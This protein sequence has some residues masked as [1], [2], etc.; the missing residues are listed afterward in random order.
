MNDRG[1][2]RALMRAMGLRSQGTITQWLDY[3]EHNPSVDKLDS[4]AAF[5]GTTVADLFASTTVVQ[6]AT[7]TAGIDSASISAGRVDARTRDLEQQLTD[8]KTR[9]DKLLADVAGAV[10]YF[11]ALVREQAQTAPPEESRPSLARRKHDR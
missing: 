10:E 5:L 2:R 7:A 1:Q 8:L 9:Y 4:I 3:A 6:D 11:G